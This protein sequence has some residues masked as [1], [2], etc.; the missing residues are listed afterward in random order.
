MRPAK[1]GL[2]LALAFT[3][4]A[5]GEPITIVSW[6]GPYEEAQTEAI[7]RPFSETTGIDVKVL[8]YDGSIDSYRERAAAE[9]WDVVDMVEDRAI[10]ACEAGLLHSFDA[11]KIVARDGKVPLRK[12]FVDG[13]FRECS[14]AQNVF[15]T[16]IAFSVQSF[17]GVKPS[18]IEDFFRCRGV[19]GKARR[20]KKPGRNS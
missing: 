1:L 4:S 20:E 10:A 15:A 11:E 19:P 8:S 12:D 2:L 9:K 6:G 16:V 7:F 3:V 17:P 14:V 13:A 18:R 5:R